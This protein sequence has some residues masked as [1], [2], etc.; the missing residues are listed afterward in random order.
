MFWKLDF[1]ILHILLVTMIAAILYIFLKIIVYEKQITIKLRY[2]TI[3]KRLDFQFFNCIMTYMSRN[4]V[5]E[6]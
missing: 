3:K 5:D 6:E 1:V 2:I 4:K